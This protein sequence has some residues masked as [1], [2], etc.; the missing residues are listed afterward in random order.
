MR[1]ICTF[2]MIIFIA[3]G[4]SGCDAL[5]RKFT[6]KKKETK[7]IPRLYQIKKYDIKP[8]AELYSKHYAYWRS[9]LSELIQSL[10]QNQKH[11]V[12]CVNEAL[13]QLHDMRNILVR[14]KADGLTK[15]MKRIEGIRATIVREK[16]DQ[17]NSNQVLIDLERE[18]RAIGRD[19]DVSRIKKYIKESFDE[20]PPADEEV[21]AAELSKTPESAVK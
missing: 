3:V 1:K 12:R 11:D 4:L 13:S 21:A 14:E 6:R 8:S 9:W 10:G 7:P 15:H 18:D 5:Q 17:F 16:L 20:A 19:F 2:V